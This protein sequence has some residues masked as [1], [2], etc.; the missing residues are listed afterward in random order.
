MSRADFVSLCLAYYIDPAVALENPD[1]REALR[2]GD[3]ER[4]RLILQ[5]DF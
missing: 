5:N 2:T 3:A 4:V 1:L